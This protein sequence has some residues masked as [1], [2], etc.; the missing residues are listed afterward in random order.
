MMFRL[1][2]RKETGFCLAPTAEEVVTTLVAGEYSL[3]PR[4]AGEPLPDQLE[5]PRRAAARAS[6]CCAAAS[7]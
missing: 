1:Q 6:A 7:S 5:V 2:D 3:V 4:P